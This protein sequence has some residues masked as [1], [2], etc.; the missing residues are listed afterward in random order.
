VVR[1]GSGPFVSAISTGIDIRVLRS[2]D[3]DIRVLR[4]TD[5][6]THAAV[7]A[8]I[9]RHRYACCRRCPD[10]PTSIRMLPSVPRSTDID[11]H[12]AVDAPIDRHRHRERHLRPSRIPSSMGFDEWCR[13]STAIDIA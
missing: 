8:L 10:R 4:S 2:T 7:D 5:I 6:D 1:T 13:I 12:T 3:I 9:D 11:T